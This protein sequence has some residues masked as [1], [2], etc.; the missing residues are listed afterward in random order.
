TPWLLVLFHVPWYNS[1]TAHQREGDRMMAAMEPL[2][3][4]AGADIVLAGHVHAYER[5]K[6]VYKGK[7]DPCGAVHITIGDGGNQ[8]GLA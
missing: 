6:R 1:N 8:E 3:Y 7:S 5:S 4:A 2:I